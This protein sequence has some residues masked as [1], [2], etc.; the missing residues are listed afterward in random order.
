M[1]KG[2]DVW[3]MLVENVPDRVSAAARL[4]ASQRLADH[5]MHASAR[6]ALFNPCEAAD[7]KKG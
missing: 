6:G 5:S 2:S 1:G 4:G 3:E 7:R